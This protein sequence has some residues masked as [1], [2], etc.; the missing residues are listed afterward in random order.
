MAAVNG[1]VSHSCL[2]Y[3][4]PTLRT[5]LTRNPSSLQ[6]QKE[7]SICMMII[8]INGVHLWKMS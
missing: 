4:G 2:L 3:A 5:E 6:E 7:D 1:Y 8:E